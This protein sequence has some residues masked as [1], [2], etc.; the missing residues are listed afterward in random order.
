MSNAEKFLENNFIVATPLI[1]TDGKTFHCLTVDDANEYARL[2]SA[3][4]NAPLVEA[5]RASNDRLISFMNLTSD[6]VSFKSTGGIIRD[7]EQLITKHTK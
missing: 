5:L 6:T 1:S 4:D 7:N 3:E 2:K